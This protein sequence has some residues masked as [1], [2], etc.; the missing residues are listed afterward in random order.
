[1]TEN[2]VVS[3]AEYQ[4]LQRIEAAAKAVVKTLT[5]DNVSWYSS[6]CEISDSKGYEVHD[7]VLDLEEA[8][9]PVKL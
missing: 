4:R 6:A 1:M 3:L 9:A 5:S 2:S 8:L 7:E